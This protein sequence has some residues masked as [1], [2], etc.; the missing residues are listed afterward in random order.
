MTKK[1]IL[2]VVII[3]VLTVGYFVFKNGSFDQINT[4]TQT[5]D[6]T[7]PSEEEIANLPLPESMTTDDNAEL[8]GEITIEVKLSSKSTGVGIIL[9]GGDKKYSCYLT[10]VTDKCDYGISEDVKLVAVPVEGFVFREWLSGC[11]NIT[12]TNLKNDT[13]EIGAHSSKKVVEVGFMKS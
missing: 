2:I 1:I 3:A 5:E 10:K 7:K 6:F 13:C 4:Q 8:A 12:T 11:D 9:L